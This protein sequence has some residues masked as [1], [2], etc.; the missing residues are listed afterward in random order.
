MT[1]QKGCPRRSILVDEGDIYDHT[2]E[3]APKVVVSEQVLRVGGKQMN[4]KTPHDPAF[5]TMCSGRENMSDLEVINAMIPFC[6]D[7]HDQWFREG[8]WGFMI[9]PDLTS[10]R[11]KPEWPWYYITLTNVSLDRF[12]VTPPLSISEIFGRCKKVRNTATSVERHALTPRIQES[13]FDP[14]HVGGEEWRALL[15]W[16]LW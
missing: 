7:V 12:Q 3:I 2:K 4:S 1:A 13:W 14:C 15:R 16:S 8:R 5:R 11:Y 6:E 10:P 9:L